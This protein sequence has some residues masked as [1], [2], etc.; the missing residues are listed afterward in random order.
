MAALTTDRQRTVDK[1]VKPWRG[2]H[3]PNAATT[4]MVAVLKFVTNS[5]V[6]DP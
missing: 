3:Q 5:V 4:E 6:A 2:V 1:E